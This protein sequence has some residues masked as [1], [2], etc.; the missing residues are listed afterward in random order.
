M[1]RHCIVLFIIICGSNLVA[2]E[3][4]LDVLNAEQ[5]EETIYAESTFKGLRLINGH[6]VV[7]RKS[8]DW[9]FVIMHRFGRIN[10]GIDDFFGL[11]VS[12][13]R[14]AM[15]YGINDNITVSLG[16]NSHEKL[17][18]GFIK[19]KLFK[20]STGVKNMPVTITGFSSVAIRTLENPNFAEDDFNSKLAYTHQLIVARKFSPE[21]SLQLIPSFVH[22]NKVMENQKNDI[23]ALGFGGRVKLNKRL[24][25]I[26]EYYYRITEE[27]ANEFNDS[28]GV[29]LEIETGGHVFQLNFT[30]SR[31][32]VEKGF[33]TETDGDFFNGDV[34]FGFNI[35]RVF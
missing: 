28:M 33:I 35:S 15:E 9:A 21:L 34:H 12:N 2:Q 26:G 27:E 19:Y 7:T 11:D 31:S 20:Q 24:S 18:D 23:F 14:F 6:T 5:T 17:Y 30:N 4:L 32:M 8:H 29:G 10:S 3:D 16:R 22:R 25:I 13:I 1:K